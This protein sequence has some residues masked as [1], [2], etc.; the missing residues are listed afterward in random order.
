MKTETK[1][2]LLVKL[3]NKCHKPG[4]TIFLTDD[5]GNPFPAVVKYG[6][7]IVGFD[8]PVVYIEPTGSYSLTRLVVENNDNKP[9][10]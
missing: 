7:G 5:S 3:F 4:D 2:Q 6:A 1:N 8:T 10:I 9:K